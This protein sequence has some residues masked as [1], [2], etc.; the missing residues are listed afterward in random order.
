MT[1]EQWRADVSSYIYVMIGL[2][3][4]T[5]N[6]WARVKGCLSKLKERR[7][8]SNDY[9]LSCL[10]L[11]LNG[12][13]EQGVGNLDAAM[14][15]FRGSYFSMERVGDPPGFERLVVAQLAILSALN[16]VIILQFQGLGNEAESTALLGHLERVCADHV[17]LEIKTAYNIVVSVRTTNPP[18]SLHQAKRLIHIGFRGAQAS[19]NAQFLSISLNTMHHKLFTDIVSDQAIKSAR[20]GLMQAKKSGNLLWMSVAAS[21]L[22]HSYEKMGDM[23]NMRMAQAEGTHWAN[24]SFEMTQKLTFLGDL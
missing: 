11:Y 5:R 23:E 10:I 19:C 17:N 22:A 1:Q 4:A 20:A 3:S 21:L 7:I 14:K 6:D 12:V 24:E 18:P 16:M 15:A 13:Y 9:D 8:G 2:H